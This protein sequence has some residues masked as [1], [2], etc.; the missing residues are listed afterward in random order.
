M[1]APPSD[2]NVAEL[3]HALSDGWSIDATELAYLP[4]GFGS[5]HWRATTSD[6][7]R[8]FVTVDVHS[9]PGTVDELRRAFAAAVALQRDAGLSFVL[10]PV[11]DAAGEPV[12]TLHGGRF[13][14]AVTSWIDAA[15]LGQHEFESAGDRNELLALL[16]HLHAATP[17]LA[18][19]VPPPVDLTPPDVQHL[20]SALDR[21]DQADAWNTGPFG[22]PARALLLSDLDRVTTALAR[23][24][25]LEAAV[26]ADRSI[27]WVI[28]HGEPHQANV[29]RGPDGSLHLIDWD[30][31][32]LAPRER[33]LWMVLDDSCDPATYHAAAD[34]PPASPL[35]LRLFRMHWDL[36]EI[37]TYLREFR[38]PHADDPN[39][40]ESWKNLRAYLP[41]N[42]DHLTPVSA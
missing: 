23:Y 29:L 7:T 37:A 20:R 11:P 28:T 38:S 4:V 18:A 12:R 40:R 19:A 6:D 32:R 5:H 16:G 8:C 26:Q 42:A 14:V 2:L 39:T 33:D 31:A 35:A 21:V 24:G 22:E 41:V 27:P 25:E 34:G 9:S 10:A 36:G 13:T 3:T 30:T 15:P 17:H 1:L